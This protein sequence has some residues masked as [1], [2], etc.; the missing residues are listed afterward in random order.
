MIDRLRMSTAISVRLFGEEEEK[1]L[2]ATDRRI[3]SIMFNHRSLAIG[4]EHDVSVIS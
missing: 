4:I 1:N 2:L 3:G